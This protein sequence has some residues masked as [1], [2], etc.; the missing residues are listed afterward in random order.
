MKVTKAVITAAGRR[1]R[2][3]P[4]Q[5]LIDRDWRREVGAAHS[6]REV[7]RAG[8][9]EICVVVHPGDEAAYADGGGRA[10]RPAAL[11]PPAGAAGL[12]PR[13]LLRAASSS[14]ATPFCTWSAT[15]CTSAAIEQSC[16]QQ[17]VERGRGRRPAPSR[18]CR[19]RARA[20]CPTIGAVGG[21]RVAGR[22][23]LY[24]VETVV[25][26]PT[27]TEAEQRLIVPGLRAGHYLCFF[28][29]H[30]LTAVGD[31]HPGR[32]AGRGAGA[33]SRQ[34]CPG[35]ALGRAGGAGR[36]ASNTW[37][38]EQ[39]DARYDVGVK[40]GLLTA[41]LALALQRP[42]PRRGA[43]PAA[44]NCWPSAISRAGESGRVQ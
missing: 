39:H 44:W 11:C 13:R 3:L 36:G 24:Q 16:A 41:Q 9:D 6:G 34:R 30:V 15:T 5:T 12:R 18:R 43:G 31:G 23:D 19:R 22:A 25:E 14:A 17:L 21:R 4:L 29:M 7:V 28:G 8:I 35:H 1:Q 10:C 32:A 33:T 38:L 26:K 20:C 42:G 2:T 37:P 27:P 40:Y